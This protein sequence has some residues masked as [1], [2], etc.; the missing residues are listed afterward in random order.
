M[1]WR[2]VIPPLFNLKKLSEVQPGASSWTTI[3]RR[4]PKWM[5][6]NVKAGAEVSRGTVGRTKFLGRYGTALVAVGAGA[7]AYAMTARLRCLLIT[8]ES[9]ARLAN[10]LASNA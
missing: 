1:P 2:G 10:P 4:L 5:K 3:D 8:A 7:T 9:L 6:P